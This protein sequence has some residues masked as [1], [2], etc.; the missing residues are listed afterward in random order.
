M[1]RILRIAVLAAV[2]VLAVLETPSG[3]LVFGF[4][5]RESCPDDIADGRCPPACTSCVCVPH[6]RAVTLAAGLAVADVTPVAGIDGLAVTPP[7][8]PRA[9]D[10]PHVPRPLSA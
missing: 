3:S 6:G 1:R 2:A 9:V 5:C 7:V 8:E 10:I 4:E